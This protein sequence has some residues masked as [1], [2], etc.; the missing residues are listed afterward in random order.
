MPYSLCRPVGSCSSGLIRSRF[1]VPASN[2]ASPPPHSHQL[3]YLS[4]PCILVSFIYIAYIIFIIYIH[5]RDMMSR[6]PIPKQAARRSA[7]RPAVSNRAS[8]TRQER[9]CREQ[10]AG[11]DEQNG[12]A[13]RANAPQ[14][15]DDKEQEETPMTRTTSPHDG[16]KDKQAP[17]SGRQGESRSPSAHRR[18]KT[19][20]QSL[21]A[22]R[23][24]KTRRHDETNM[25]PRPTR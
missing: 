12:D 2:T 16:N 3:I 19:R 14:P 9:C 18:D 24:E 21:P 15:Y 25:T 1:I 7:S 4:H 22:P 8:G 10:K 17:A 20:N 13:A 23:D 6:T 5:R 11:D